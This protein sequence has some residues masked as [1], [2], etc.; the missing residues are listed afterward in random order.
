MRIEILRIRVAVVAHTRPT[1][2][3]TSMETSDELGWLSQLHHVCSELQTLQ[4]RMC[5]IEKSCSGAV[6]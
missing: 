2:S 5:G 3:H 1:Y 4:L 6:G